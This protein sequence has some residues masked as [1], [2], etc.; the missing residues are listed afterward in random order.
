MP[1]CCTTSVRHVA[2][3]VVSWVTNRQ[4]YQERMINVSTS[5]S[6]TGLDKF[7]NAQ[8]DRK[9]DKT[10]YK[11][12]DGDTLLSIANTYKVGLQ[13]LRFYNNVP[14]TTMAIRVG[15]TLHIPSAQVILP[16]DEA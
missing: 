1:M 15:Q 7:G 9:A 11:V 10:T 12:K 16:A 8:F 14:K 4:I 3:P 13:Q 2:I 5:I 6:M